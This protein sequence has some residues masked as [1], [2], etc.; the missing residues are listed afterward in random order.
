MVER[1]AGA[2]LVVHLTAARK[3]REGKRQDLLFKCMAP[4]I[5][6]LRLSPN[7]QQSIQQSLHTES[8]SSSKA[9]EKL[10][11]YT[12][13][14][15]NASHIQPEHNVSGVGVWIV[16]TH[17]TTAEYQVSGQMLLK[18]ELILSYIELLCF[19]DLNRT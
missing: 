12:G 19:E 14:Q 4:K 18:T 16:E 11:Q 1:L 5:C 13:L 3:Q 8:N 17:L 10:T 15:Q 6:S 7:C 9:P 2:Q